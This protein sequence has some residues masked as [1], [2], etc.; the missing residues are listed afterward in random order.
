MSYTIEGHTADYKIKVKGKTLE[1]AF[2]SALLG[3]FFYVK[4]RCD[5]KDRNVSRDIAL[6]SSSPTFLLIEFLSECLRLSQVNKEVYTDIEF[7]DFAPN[8]ILARVKG[9]KVKSFD[10]EIKAVTYHEADLKQDKNGAW[11]TNEYLW[12][13]PKSFQKEMLAPAR[14]YASEKLLLQILRD[15]SIQQL[16]NTASI[17][18]I[19]KYALVMP[20]AHEGY[21]F[22]IGRVAATSYP[23]GYICPGG[24]GYDINCGVRLLKARQNAKDI[25]HMLDS[26]A[27]AF[28]SEIPSGVGKGGSIVLSKNDLDDVLADGVSWAIKRGYGEEADLFNIESSG[29]LKEADPKAVSK[30]AKERGIVQLGTMGAGNHFVEIGR[31]DEIFDENAAK[32]FGLSLNQITIMIYTGSRGLGHQVASD[33]LKIVLE[34]SSAQNIH[35]KDPELTGSSLQLPEGKQYFSAMCAAANFAWA[36]RQLITHIVR[37]IWK[38]TFGADSDLSILYDVAHNIAKIEE[39]DIFGK[40]K[41]VIV[42]RKG[43]TRAFWG[44]PV[45][46]PGSI[47]SSSYVLRGTKQN[48]EET[49]G[50]TCHGAGRSMS[51]HAAQ[52]EFDYNKLDSELKLDNI[53]IRTGSKKGLVEEAPKAY[54]DIDEVIRTVVNANIAEKIAKLEP[55]A[56][57]KG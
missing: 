16:I 38:K 4:K 34:A 18:G 10:D 19:Q 28:Y 51:R 33:Y 26:L 15:R 31:V 5:N 48:L 23:D 20:D 9:C 6:E 17:P 56:V 24:I 55:L 25:N 21:G 45:I 47:G 14:I 37:N 54:K 8:K 41:K 2:K 11:G 40:K 35:L 44:Q 30:H 43:A 53:H 32:D 12:E 36:N 22:P 49:F 27:N 57:I 39:H 7:K 3:M 29:S 50:S 13:I 46:I 42:H 52:K 1:E